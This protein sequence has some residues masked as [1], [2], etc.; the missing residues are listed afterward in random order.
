MCVREEGGR[1]GLNLAIHQASA[2][3]SFKGSPVGRFSK[4]HPKCPLS[5]LL[6]KSVQKWRFKFFLKTVF[7]NDIMTNYLF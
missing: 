1:H 3:T 2:Y 4:L 6:K 5:V 7:K